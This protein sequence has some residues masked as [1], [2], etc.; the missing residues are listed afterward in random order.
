MLCEG[1]RKLRYVSEAVLSE[2]GNAESHEHEKIILKEVKTEQSVTCQAHLGKCDLG[3]PDMEAAGPH[4]NDHSS[5]GKQQGRE[6][7]SS[8]YFL[9][10]VKRV[11]ER[12]VP[13]IVLE[14]VV[15]GEFSDLVSGA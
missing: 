2:L 10:H 4:C 15:K 12:E 8:K 13:L 11:V 6:G 1:F 14:N 3:N 7:Q 9:L 5:W